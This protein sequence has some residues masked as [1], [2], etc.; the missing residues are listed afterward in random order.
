MPFKKHNWVEYGYGRDKIVKIIVERAK[1]GQL[2]HFKTN[3]NRDYR[4]IL[5]I[6]KDRH[7]FNFKSEKEVD[8]NSTI[9]K[10]KDWLKKEIDFITPK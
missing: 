2:D 10:E 9:E 3:N 7:G 8:K 4:K 1:G 5:K 6:L